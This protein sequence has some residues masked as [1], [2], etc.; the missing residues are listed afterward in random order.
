MHF[1]VRMSRDFPYLIRDATAADAAAIADIFNE[2]IRKSPS[3]YLDEEVSVQSRV[4]L[5]AERLAAGFPFR[6]AV[7]APTEKDGEK[8]NHGEVAAF[9]TYGPFRNRSGYRHTVEHSLYVH[10]DHRGRG[11]GRALLREVLDIA[12]ARGVHVVVAGADAENAASLALH[13]QFEFVEV[14]RMPEVG[15]K[16]G[17]WRT[18]VFMQKVL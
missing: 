15:R 13:K 4:D 10:R 11:L 1:V 14:A 12:R 5:V 8:N 6:V 9:V 7:V 18:L 2:Q 16:F 3:V 17:E